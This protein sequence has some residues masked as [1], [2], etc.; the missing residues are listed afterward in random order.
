MQNFI[1][2]IIPKIQLWTLEN[3]T[4][5][6]ISDQNIK[7]VLDKLKQNQENHWLQV[8]ATKLLGD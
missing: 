8:S 7:K 4:A 1:L 5:T 6:D 3:K 2:E